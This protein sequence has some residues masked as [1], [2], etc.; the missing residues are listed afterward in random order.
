M[1]QAT[2]GLHRRLDRGADHQIRDS[3]PTKGGAELAQRIWG[4]YG[5]SPG[6]IPMVVTQRLARRATRLAD[7]RLPLLAHVQ[8]RWSPADVSAQRAWLAPHP[9]WPLASVDALSSSAD[10]APRIA[11]A[12]PAKEPATT[13]RPPIEH[14]RPG[15]V[16]P[17]GPRSATPTA[18]DAVDLKPAIPRR[19]LAGPAGPVVR[20]KVGPPEPVMA[21]LPMGIRGLR[22]PIAEEKAAAKAPGRDAF[23][24]RP[25]SSAQGGAGVAP[26][27]TQRLP[28]A[29]RPVPTVRAASQPLPVAGPSP[30][31]Q[32]KTDKALTADAAAKAPTMAD[33]PATASAGPTKPAAS[34]ATGTTNPP[35]R[36]APPFSSTLGAPQ[37]RMPVLGT[38]TRGVGAAGAEGAMLIQTRPADGHD[39]SDTPLVLSPPTTRPASLLARQ[40]L[41]S[42]PTSST[43]TT[44]VSRPMEPAPAS[45]PRVGKETDVD[46]LVDKVLHR[47]MR[48]LAVEGERRGWPRWP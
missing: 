45:A 31:I 11:S 14:I 46:E 34:G 9:T 18:T 35:S 26:Q 33:A 32:R 22:P 12:P 48:R 3:E 42:P 8:R 44:S 15:T 21:H 1:T 47:L 16:G 23:E 40:E 17:P 30:A 5:G 19:H 28:R 41:T 10:A 36:P 29:E 4:R 20:R 24:A 6:V 38:V 27:R 43:P 7:G 37:P 39:R 25:D 13:G 2:E